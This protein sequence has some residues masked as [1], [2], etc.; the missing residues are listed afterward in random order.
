MERTEA[1]PTR[2]KLID[3]ARKL[4]LERGYEGVSIRDVTEAAG[5]NV[6]SINYH[7]GGKE[8]LYREVFRELLTARVSDILGRLDAVISEKSPPDLGKVFRTYLEGLLGEFLVSGEAQ[9]FAKLVSNEMS[10]NG[11]AS[12]ILVRE[13]AVPIHRVLKGAILAARPDIADI[14]A[15]LIIASIF[16]QM[17]HFVRAR[18]VIEHTM[19]RSYDE[20]F[21]R[22][23]MDHIVEFSL[24]GMGER[25]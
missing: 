15:S 23:I 3:S 19:A 20:E 21:V 8:N 6:A 5:A 22:V 9:N 4:F 17:F 14:K 13:A 11:L 10:E 25:P 7:F 1:K 2:R 16:G 18:H 12:E 24:K